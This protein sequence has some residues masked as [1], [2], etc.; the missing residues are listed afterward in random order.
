MPTLPYEENFRECPH[1]KRDAQFHPHS[2]A[3]VS[4][5]ED[6]WIRQQGAVPPYDIRAR[7]ELGLHWACCQSC[8]RATVWDGWEM[9]Y[10][11][12]VVG[13]APNEDLEADIRQTFDEARAIAHRSPRGAIVL[14]RWCLERMLDQVGIKR[15]ESGRFLSLD[16]RLRTLPLSSAQES[17]GLE[18]ARIIKDYGNWAVHHSVPVPD[19]GVIVQLMEILNLLVERHVSHPKRVEMLGAQS[20]ARIASLRTGEDSQADTSD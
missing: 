20:R 14:L 15:E 12:P 11:S 5:Y 3:G 19:E 10:P 4:T 1:C 2:T 6:A 13:P 7:H 17:P 8:G 9:V 16:Q 18:T